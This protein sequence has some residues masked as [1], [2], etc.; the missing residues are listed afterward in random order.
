MFIIFTK[1]RDK[2]IGIN[3]LIMNLLLFFSVL[4]PNIDLRSLPS[5][6]LEH[7]LLVL[8]FL[9]LI[10]KGIFKKKIDFKVYMLPLLLVVFAFINMISIANGDLS[11]Y[12]IVI[13]DIFELYKVLV[14]VLM[15]VVVVNLLT[16]DEEKIGY[17]KNLNIFIMISNIVALTQYINLF[18][19]NVRYIKYIAPSQQ[20]ALMPGYMFP[21]SV[22]LSNNPNV[23]AYIV[24]VGLI[25]S[26]GLFLYTK[27]KFYIFTLGTNFM[28]LLM[29]RSRTG[30]VM[31]IVAL[32]VFMSFYIV[33]NILKGKIR[34]RD[35]G[36]LIGA[37]G[38]LAFIAI[39]VFL[40]VLP[41]SLT[42]RI[43]ELFNLST[44]GS[45]NARLG[46]W[47]EYI[48]YFFKNPIIGTGPVKSIAYQYQPDNE[49]ILLLKRYGIVGSSFFILS[50]IVPI[51]LSWKRLKSS[52]AGMIFISIV[53][54]SFIYMIPAVV[55]HSFQ[56]MSLLMILAALALARP[57]NREKIR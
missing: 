23:Y 51:G 49:W 26:I 6:R 16:S 31:F 32:T 55:Y 40:F 54:A 43:K 56:L 19:L 20:R 28:A 33:E 30:F 46:V 41:D 7:V 5:I 21:R 29:T 37:I 12:R 48:E 22:G 42:W 36:K 34:R 18:N 47:G 11:G 39:F 24:V 52:L 8:S 45:W 15:F 53:L 2:K 10:S 17:L 38:L 25:L 1:I 27:R 50:F 35:K 57:K 13:N 14:Y 9:Y 4:S 44:A 3:V